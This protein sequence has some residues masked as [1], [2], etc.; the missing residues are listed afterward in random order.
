ME[1]EQICTIGLSELSKTISQSKLS[2]IKHLLIEYKKNYIDLHEGFLCTIP[3][4]L[5]KFLLDKGVSD[6][7]EYWPRL[8]TPL[9]NNNYKGRDEDW[10]GFLDKKW[11]DIRQ[12]CDYFLN[13]WTWTILPTLSKLGQR[14]EV[15]W[16][17][18]IPQGKH[19]RISDYWSIN[20]IERKA[21]TQAIRWHP[22]IRAG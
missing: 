9:P 2:K 16:I 19:T 3:T 17:C 18:D 22:K 7:V 15:G 11:K 6:I 14:W 12:T 21:R 8:G 13:N 4:M 10:E 20:F 1:D 5:H